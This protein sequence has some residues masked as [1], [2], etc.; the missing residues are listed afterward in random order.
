MAKTKISEYSS[1]SAG[2]DLNTDIA[3]IN[4]DENCSPANINNAIRALMAQVKDLQSGVSGDTIPVA[5]GGT[6]SANASTART[7]LSAAV[8][9]ANSD[10]TSLSGLTTPLSIAQGGTGYTT[11]AT[12]ST[13]GRLSNVVTI[14]TTSAHGFVTG[15]TVTVTAGTNT[16]INGAYTIT[17]T[18][19]STSFTYALSGTNI[20]T[21]SDTGTA[22]TSSQRYVN[23]TSNVT[24][25]LPLS[26]GGLGVTSLTKNTLIVGNGT[27]AFN[28][29]KPSTNG[30]VVTS[31]AGSTV[32]AADL[33]EGVEYTILTVGSTLTN[34]TS[35]GASLGTVGE[36][37]TKNST[38]ATGN[39]TATENTF[40]MESIPLQVVG[41]SANTTTAGSFVTNVYYT[42]LTVGT[43]DF[44]LIGASSNTVGVIFKATGAGSGTGTATSFQNGSLTLGGFKVIWGFATITS[45]NDET[46]TFHTAFSVAP[47]FVT[48]D[49]RN[50]LGSGNDIGLTKTGFT[51]NRNDS[52]SG[53]TL[54]RYL[55]IG[56]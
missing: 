1:T 52:L 49:F 14:T 7:A 4:I 19:T 48:T 16:S 32:N 37:F 29:L 50:D 17:G 23:L 33:V 45:D 10:I 39:G 42:I 36:V 11:N 22:V 8:S 46:I 2:A 26:K 9:G 15:D 41:S 13:V 35:I 56:Y 6:G 30:K 25:T 44:T 3:S 18:P 47:L 27:S 34:W 43:T 20:S 53:T 55:A 54:V 31:K 51:F 38:A 24:G 40:S 5:A 21:V 28:S 12:I